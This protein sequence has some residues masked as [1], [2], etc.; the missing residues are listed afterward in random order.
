LT[1]ST[2]HIIVDRTTNHI[3]YLYIARRKRRWYLLI[4]SNSQNR[5]WS[6]T[7]VLIQNKVIG[8]LDCFGCL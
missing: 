3:N 7:S 6:K 4:T 8:K 5:I 2:I 1:L